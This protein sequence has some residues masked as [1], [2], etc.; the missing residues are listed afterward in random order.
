MKKGIS[1]FLHALV[2]PLIYM[3]SQVVASFA[4]VI[5][6]TITSVIEGGPGSIALADIS[7]IQNEFVGKYSQQILIAACVISC[8]IVLIIIKAR[9]QK[10]RDALIIKR[11]PYGS[12]LPTVV[13][14]ISVNLA[15]VYAISIIPIPET[16]LEQYNELVGETIIS[17]NFLMTFFTT[18]L[19]V[20]FTEEVMF[21]GMSFNALRRGMS[22][23]LA[24][25]LQTLIFA[26]AHMLPL[27]VAYVIP[28]SMVLGLVYVW[29]DTIIAPII[30]HIAYNG[31]STILSALPMPEEE[32]TPP[33]NNTVPIIIIA[34]ALVLTTVCLIRLYRTY[35]TQVREAIVKSQLPISPGEMR[36]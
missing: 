32:I 10:L 24:T 13:L 26:G 1:S 20:P 34:V 27:Q 15:T 21:R 36:D 35:K 5:A 14:G 4:A 17:D 12:I 25:V 7:T 19:L 9:R 28:A 22:V 8:L 18:A 2:Y 3:G 16:V 31:F 6:Y 29:C 30:M 11:M 33:E 23:V